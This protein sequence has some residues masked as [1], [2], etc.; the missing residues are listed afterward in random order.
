MKK[1]RLSLAAL[2]F[3]PMGAMACPVLQGVQICSGDTVVDQRTNAVGSVIG[4]NPYT[5][6][7]SHQSAYGFVSTTNLRDL[8]VGASRGA[9]RC[10]GVVCTGDTVVDQRSNRVGKA[11]AMNPFTG[12]ISSQDAYGF[13]ATSPRRSTGLAY[14]CVNGACAGDEVID[15]RTNQR[16][17]V[18]AVNVFDGM[19][20]IQTAYGFVSSVPSQSVAILFGSTVYESYYRMRPIWRDGDVHDDFRFVWGNSRHRYRGHPGHGPGPGPRPLPPR[21]D[22]RRDDDRRPGPGRGDDR[23]PGPGRDD[24]RRPGPGRGDDRRDDRR[25]GRGGPPGR[26]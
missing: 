4:V 15:T 5:A 8:G 6:D 2:A 7:I 13:V 1:S 18:I 20:S 12:A 24:D 25:D 17:R 9:T 3:A 23:R 11:I 16:G 10:L 22:D 26:R 19:L 14:G 21:H